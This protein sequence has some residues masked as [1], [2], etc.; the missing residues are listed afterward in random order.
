MR[1]SFTRLTN[2]FSKK[3]ANHRSAV[4]IHFMHY[5]W[6]CIH[7]ALRVTPAME[8]GLPNRLWSLEDLVGFME[9]NE[10]ATI[11]TESN[12]RGPHRKSSS[13]SN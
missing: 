12:K 4:A 10:R 7:K 2:G 5:N 3:V 1:D 9:A 6:V 13:D 11:G 8:A